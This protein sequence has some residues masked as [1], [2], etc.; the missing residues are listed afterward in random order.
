M[1][2]VGR[3]L[4]GSI[5]NSQSPLR[6]KS[7]FLQRLYNEDVVPCMT[8]P[9]LNLTAKVLEAV[10]ANSLSMSPIVFPKEGSGELP[11]H[12][13]LFESALIC[14]FKVTLEDCTTMEISQLARNRIAATCECLNYL[15]YICEGLVKAHHNE[16]FWEIMKR[17][18]KMSLAKLGY[19]PDED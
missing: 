8:F 15:R 3:V 4:R 1:V 13:A 11:K 2:L 16:V 17:R 18:K 7:E 14:Q 19:S 6:S 10:E 5:A 12:C 9:N